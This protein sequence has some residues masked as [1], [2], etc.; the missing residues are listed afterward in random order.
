LG[1]PAWAHSVASVRLAHRL[2]GRTLSNVFHVLDL[3]GAGSDAEFRLIAETLRDVWANGYGGVT[4]AS[5]FQGSGVELLGAR[6]VYMPIGLGHLK[7]LDVE[8]VLFTFPPGPG[9]SLPAS[10]TIVTDAWCADAGRGGK[11]WSYFPWLGRD[12]ISLDDPDHITDSARDGVED[13]YGS[14]LTAF[15]DLF[16]PL[17]FR[18]VVYHRNG[19]VKPGAVEL[20]WWDAIDAYHVRDNRLTSLDVRLPGWKRRAA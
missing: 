17:R 18:L 12:C 16:D 13:A 2:A 10:C 4:A 19:R 20:A 9:E 3:T 5:H 11:G 1:E 15:A 7:Y 14:V 6:V 8:G